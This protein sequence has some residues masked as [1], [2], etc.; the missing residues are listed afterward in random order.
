MQFSLIVFCLLELEIGIEEWTMRGLMG[1]QEGFRS[2]DFDN[3]EKNKVQ[4]LKE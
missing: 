1:Y 3:F 4:V 2:Q